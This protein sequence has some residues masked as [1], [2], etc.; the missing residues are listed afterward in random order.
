MT[1][2]F[3]RWSCVGTLLVV[4]S[5]CG[6]AVDE[7]PE[8]YHVFGTVTF[9][10]KPLERGMIYFAPTEANP[11][12]EGYAKI[13]EGRYDTKLEGNKGHIG[14]ALLVRIK[15]EGAVSANDE[16]TKAPF[17]QWATEVDLPRSDTSKNFDVPKEAAIE[18]P[19]R[20]RA[21]EV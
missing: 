7:G 14:G 3:R 2:R 6:G 16:P 10:G 5:G 11:G 13:V 18:K 17:E 19:S 15:A 12:P 21:P 1:G 8:R 20:P 9:D 4:L